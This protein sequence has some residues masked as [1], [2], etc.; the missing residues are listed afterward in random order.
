[1]DFLV[2]TSQKFNKNNWCAFCGFF[3]CFRLLRQ[4]R[5]NTT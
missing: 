5:T 4:P 3:Y 1:M 2:K